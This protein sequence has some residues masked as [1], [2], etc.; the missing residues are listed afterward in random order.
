MHAGLTTL[1]DIAAHHTDHT[2]ALEQ[3]GCTLFSPLLEHSIRTPLGTNLR[4]CLNQ[5]IKPSNQ[6]RP[7]RWYYN[8]KQA[9]Q[10]ACQLRAH[11]NRMCSSPPASS[12]QLPAQMVRHITHTHINNNRRSQPAKWGPCFHHAVASCKHNAPEQLVA[13]GQEQ[14]LM[15]TVCT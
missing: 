8:N 12:I 6:N 4:N 5:E 15:K 13:L 3:Q 1:C 7:G 11:Y 10:Q 2:V 14:M 9:Q